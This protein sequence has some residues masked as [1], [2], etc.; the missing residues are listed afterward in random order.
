[1]GSGGGQSVDIP[2]KMHVGFGTAISKLLEVIDGHSLAQL[3]TDVEM[4]KT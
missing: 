2:T 3:A 1:M 4:R